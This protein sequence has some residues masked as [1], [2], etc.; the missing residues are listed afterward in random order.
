MGS[1]RVRGERQRVFDL[2]LLTAEMSIEAVV[3][4]LWA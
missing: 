4:R 1:R 3:A 2:P